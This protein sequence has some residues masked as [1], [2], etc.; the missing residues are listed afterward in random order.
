MEYEVAVEKV[1]TLIRKEIVELL[2][3]DE[4]DEAHALHQAKTIVINA[5]HDYIEMY[6]A[7]QMLRSVLSKLS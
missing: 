4:K 2:E 7:L 3:D 6:T 1:A 5:L